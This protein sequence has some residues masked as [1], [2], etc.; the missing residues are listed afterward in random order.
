MTSILGDALP[1]E[2][3]YGEWLPIETAPRD[4]ALMLVYASRG[5]AEIRWRY[6]LASWDYVESAWCD[7]E[8][9]E[10]IYGVTHWMPLPPAPLPATG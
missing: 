10:P 2:P 9:G 7:E 4:G 1:R 6:H 8:D 3:R 5:G